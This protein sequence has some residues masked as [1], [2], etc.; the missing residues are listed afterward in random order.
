M[1]ARD[2][3][4]PGMRALGEH[5]KDILGCSDET[6]A[7]E[8]LHMTAFFRSLIAADREHNGQTPQAEEP[9]R[10]P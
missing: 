2:P 6:A 9:L 3:R 10:R 8:A 1:V 5:L 4:S 7:E